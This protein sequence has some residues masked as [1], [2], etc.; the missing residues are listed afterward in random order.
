M[1]TR[2]ARGICYKN[3]GAGA[4]LMEGIFCNVKCNFYNLKK[5][6]YT[7][8]WPLK[9]LRLT[10]FLIFLQHFLQNIH[11]CLTVRW[12]KMLVEFIVP[13]VITIL[14]RLAPGI[15]HQKTEAESGSP[16]RQ[17]CAFTRP[18][19]FTIISIWIY[20]LFHFDYDY[21]SDNSLLL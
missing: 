18:A 6:L 5:K 21:W 11:P 4:R 3:W 8:S 2:P 9:T 7:F 13:I 20:K 16:D 1:S 10:N 14:D 17:N 12:R 15:C 19:K